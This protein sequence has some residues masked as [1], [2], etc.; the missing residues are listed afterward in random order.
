M[1][2]HLRKEKICPGCRLGGPG[3]FQLRQNT[4]VQHLLKNLPASLIGK[5][6]GAQPLAIRDFPALSVHDGGFS[7]LSFEFYQDFRLIQKGL[8]AAISRKNQS[9]IFQKVAREQVGDR[10]FAAADATRH[11]PGIH[12]RSAYKSRQ[13]GGQ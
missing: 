9:F 5:D 11:N 3:R 7:E 13:A 10:T 12:S 1:Q 2:G 6:L 8:G 4:G